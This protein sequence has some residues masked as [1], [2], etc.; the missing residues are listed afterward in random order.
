MAPQPHW[1][2]FGAFC[3]PG[4]KIQSK[5]SKTVR[6]LQVKKMVDRIFSDEY[7]AGGRTLQTAVERG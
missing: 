1:V 2:N 7:E 3:P 5:L 4:P 6:E